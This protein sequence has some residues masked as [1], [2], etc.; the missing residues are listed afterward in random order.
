MP[1]GFGAVSIELLIGNR[2]TSYI[3]HYE[4]LLISSV[5]W[6]DGGLSTE[7]RSINIVGTGLSPCA[8]CLDKE[9]ASSIDTDLDVS[10]NAITC[11]SLV[12]FGKP[13]IGCAVPNEFRAIVASLY[14]SSG[15]TGPI[16]SV[17]TIDF[18]IVNS[19][20]DV[21]PSGPKRIIPFGF[22]NEGSE[23]ALKFTS[24]SDSKMLDGQLFLR[25]KGSSDTPVPFNYSFKSLL[26]NDPVIKT[27]T[28]S[29]LDPPDPW[30]ITLSK[31]GGNG[32]RV[33]LR[34]GKS[35]LSG[36]FFSIECPTV[37]NT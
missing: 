31:A 5:S 32:G 11:R 30:N 14:N 6:R 1:P 18:K 24:D 3:V 17:S 22:A 8:L 33:I 27:V 4:P 35:S 10:N 7:T 15:S 26:I 25:F 12:P 36:S 29:L 2:S 34:E 16:G 21:Y 23:G 13:N 19:E 20:G 9:M 37:W 28:S